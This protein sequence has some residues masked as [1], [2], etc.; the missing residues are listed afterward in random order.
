M[1]PELFQLIEDL[2][3]GRAFSADFRH[4]GRVNFWSVR[5][6]EYIRDVFWAV[7]GR[8]IS[9]PRLSRQNAGN[10]LLWIP[11]GLLVPRELVPW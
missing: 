3:F 11:Q 10:D 4:F 7:Q 5:H 8:L 6:Q 9:F 1:L 2:R